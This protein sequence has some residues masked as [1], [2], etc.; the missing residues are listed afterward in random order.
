M[1]LS[2]VNEIS[3]YDSLYFKKLILK[4]MRI[5]QNYLH[6]LIKENKF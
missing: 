3:K 2:F 4:I 1:C 5:Y 6:S